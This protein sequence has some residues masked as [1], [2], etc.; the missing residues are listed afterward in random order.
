MDREH[1]SARVTETLLPDPS[2]VSGYVGLVGRPNCGKSTFLNQALGQIVSVTHAKPQT[3]RQRILGIFTTDDAQI[4]FMDTPGLHR[5]RN[6]LGRYMMRQVDEALAECDALLWLADVTRAPGADEERLLDRLAERRA[7]TPLPAVILGFNKIDALGGREAQLESRMEAYWTLAAARLDMD[8][9]QEWTG[10][11]LSALTGFGVPEVLRL[12]RSRLPEGP[13][14]YPA[15]QITDQS[16]RAIA[17]DLIRKQALECLDEEIPHGIA[18]EI[19][20]YAERGP[21]LTYIAATLYVER[22]SHKPIALGYKGRLIRRMGALARQDIEA[23]I[24]TRVYL[25]LWVKVRKN[26]RKRPSMLRLLGYG[27]S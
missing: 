2:Y 3:T 20:E 27:Q 23:L 26:W 15:D 13:Q 25:D 17:E 1:A 8:V 10:G 21:D 7:R 22:E 4:I 18:V 24:E 11:A 19:T 12:V 9:R 6:Q 14:Y 5:P 16:V